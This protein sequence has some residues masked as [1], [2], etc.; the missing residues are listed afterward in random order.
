MNRLLLLMLLVALFMSLHALQT[1]EELAMHTL[2]EAKHAVNR[3]A[4]AAVLQI[5]PMQWA[6]GNAVID[7]EQAYLEARR[8]LREN[9]R[10]DD[11]LA[12]LPG[13]FLREP[14]EIVVWKVIQNDQPFPYVFEN[15]AYSYRVT[16]NRPGVIMIAK[17]SYP[18][19]FT[20]MSPVNWTV[21]GA[22]E[23]VL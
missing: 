11:N 5:D 8:Y 2:F 1:D 10:L 6:K 16:L 21:K 9:L 3:A 19:V 13:S 7:E 15:D 12:P 23:L 20:L 14:V 22:A 17:L 4:H 18:R